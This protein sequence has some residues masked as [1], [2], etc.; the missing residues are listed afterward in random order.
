M[1]DFDRNG[2]VQMRGEKE[3]GVPELS[4]PPM[5]QTD[6]SLNGKIFGIEKES[7]PRPKGKEEVQETTIT[8]RF[9]PLIKSGFK[10]QK[11]LGQFVQGRPL[12]FFG[13]AGSYNHFPENVSLDSYSTIHGWMAW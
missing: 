8:K 5:V 6:L 9:L 1:A 3:S 12:R 10:N 4:V 7:E 2:K 13:I 11:K